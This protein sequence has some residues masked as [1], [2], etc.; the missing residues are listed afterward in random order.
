[1]R[2]QEASNARSPRKNQ[3]V[4]ARQGGGGLAAWGR[5]F[6]G[7]KAVRWGGK[8]ILAKRTTTSDL[9]QESRPTGAPRRKEK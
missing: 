7:F 4:Q 3:I 8:E 9:N 6:L 2:L 1:M 5:F